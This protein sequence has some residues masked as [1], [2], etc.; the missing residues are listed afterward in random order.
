MGILLGMAP[1]IGFAVMTHFAPPA[2]SLWVAAVVSGLLIVKEV[3][4]H[5]SVKVLEAG[6]FVLFGTLGTVAAIAPVHWDTAI[7]RSMID[8]GLLCIMLLSLVLRRPFTLQYAREQVPSAVAQ[9]PLFVRTNYIITA[10]WTVAMTI[11]VVADL[12]LHSLTS[13]PVWLGTVVISASLTGALGFTTWYP[14]RLRQSRKL[15]PHYE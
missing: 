12:A 5:R 8:A 14:K 2:S 11:V 3:L 15:K 13:L 7:V 10:V 1:F 6:T 4:H 9:L